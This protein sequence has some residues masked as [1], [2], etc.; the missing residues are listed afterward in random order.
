MHRTAHIARNRRRRSQPSSTRRAKLRPFWSLGDA[1]AKRG[2]CSLTMPHGGSSACREHRESTRER[3]A[4]PAAVPLGAPWQNRW[5]APA[6]TSRSLSPR[7][8]AECEL[9]TALSMR[10]AAGNVVGV[11][12]GTAAALSGRRSCHR[13]PSRQRVAAL[14]VSLSQVCLTFSLSRAEKVVT[15]ST[16]CSLLRRISSVQPATHECRWIE[17]ANWL[18]VLF[19]QRSGPSLDF[20]EIYFHRT[21]D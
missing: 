4:R 10:C 11:H 12:S 13:G 7:C 8:A 18:G 6:W 21:L 9:H 17:L 2:H 3:C 1:R 16:A 14:T 19:V 20:T 5:W 15:L